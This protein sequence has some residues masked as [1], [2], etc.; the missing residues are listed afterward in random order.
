MYDPKAK[1]QDL[2]LRIQDKSVDPAVIFELMGFIREYL[3]E[4]N[5]KSEFPLANMYCNW[6]VHTKIAS[7]TTGWNIMLK[8]QFL[9]IEHYSG[10]P[11]R[12]LEEV[13]AAIGRE[14]LRSELISIFERM[15]LEPIYFSGTNWG[16]TSGA[17]FRKIIGKPIIFSSRES[18]K[19][20]ETQIE[21]KAGREIFLN[22]QKFYF[23]HD[24]EKNILRWVVENP[25]G[26]KIMGDLR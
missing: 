6:C 12:L 5:L 1:I 20:I 17:I 25:E 7:S 21:R 24:D 19:L 9:L 15:G 10:S 11:N 16:S 8:V 3:E 13:D 26:G 22:I 23:I 4:N 14:N 18:S 2:S